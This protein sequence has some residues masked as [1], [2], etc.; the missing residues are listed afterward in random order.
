MRLWETFIIHVWTHGVP[1]ALPHWNQLHLLVK[2]LLELN[3]LWIK[4]VTGVYW[5]SSIINPN[6]NY[7]N[8]TSLGCCNLRYG[9]ISVDI[10][11]GW[12]ACDTHSCSL[13]RFSVRACAQLHARMFVLSR[14]VMLHVW[15]VSSLTNLST[16]TTA[17]PRFSKDPSL[18][19]ETEITWIELLAWRVYVLH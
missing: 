15:C 3:Q 14:L 18:R 8:G 2:Y 12:S 7:V 16:K 5:F 6:R 11:H 4:P 17:R 10:K 13:Q 1:M 9:Y 19:K